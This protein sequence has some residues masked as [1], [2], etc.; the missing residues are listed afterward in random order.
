MPAEAQEYFHLGMTYYMLGQEERSR[1]AL[2]RALSLNQEF[3]GKEEAVRRLGLLAING[4]TAGP[5]VL[6]S[7]ERELKEQPGDP[8]VLTRLAAIYQRGGEP[9]KALTLYQA[10]LKL[11]PKNVAVLLNLALLNSGALHNPQR[12]LDLA[13]E[14]YK[15]SPDDPETSCALGRLAFESG[16]HKWALSL[17]EQV[18]DTREPEVRYDLALAYY[19]V[20]RV[21][22]AEATMRAALEA[23]G[24]FS[25]MNEAKSF[26]DLAPLSINPAK[27]LLAESRAAEL[28]KSRPD[29]PPA[30]MV[31]GLCAEHRGEAQKARQDYEKVLNRFPEFVP[32]RKHLAVLYADLGDEKAYEMAAK[33]REALPE[34]TAVARAMGIAFFLRKDYANAARLLEESVRKGSADG[35]AMYYLGMSHYKLSQQTKD[36]PREQRESK[37]AL[38]RAL[39]LNVQSEFAETA[40][41]VLSE[42]K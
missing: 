32:V 11:N 2:N 12:A 20:G 1:N 19:S 4:K 21:A 31:A 39:A 5:D 25:R 40:R 14:A 37:A 15:L 28:L 6:A 35:K 23:G 3:T 26:L 22:E 41:R 8:I 17:L 24:T 33:A 36:Q 27:A 29:D 13:K 16:D 30:L 9:D 34:D 7:L 10:A 38:Q 18:K 42:L